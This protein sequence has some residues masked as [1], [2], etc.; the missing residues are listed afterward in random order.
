MEK[1]KIIGLELENVKRVSLLT[2]KPSV[3]GLTII[4]GDNCQGKTSIL[5]AICYALGGEKHRPS[6]LKR[7]GA[8]AD[9]Y[10]KLELSNGLVVERKG[11]ISALKVTDPTGRKAGQAILDGFIEELALNLPK[12]MEGSAKEKAKT[13]LQ[14]LGIG[15]K[16]AEL[17]NKENKFYNERHGL[18]VIADR[19]EKYAKEMP[20]YDNVPEVPVTPSE[21]LATHKDI[22]TRNGEIERARNLAHTIYQ[23]IDNSVKRIEDLAK[24][25]EIERQNLADL[26][27]QFKTARNDSASEPESTEDIEKQLADIEA[28]NLKVNANLDKAKA[29]E[30]AETIRKD[31]NVLTASIEAVRND[32]N[33]L[34]TSAQMPLPGLSVEDGEL[35]LNGKKWDCMS[36]SEQLRASTAIVRALNPKC[37]FV[38]MDKLEAMDCATLQSFGEWLEKEGLQAIATRVSKGSECSIII[39]DGRAA[40]AEPVEIITETKTIPP[41]NEAEY[42]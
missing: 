14:I 37:G 27:L 13:L 25:I 8:L 31:V 10:I 42:F 15:D 9:P 18:G 1:I 20:W 4:G 12:F 32:R 28:T 6:N 40:T 34:L 38:L 26:E 24:Q 16:L 11:K 30:D 2:M 41:A 22:V 33:A 7:D 5:D 19:K 23:Q 17:D 21:L 29:L 39:E 36:H 3:S 35:V